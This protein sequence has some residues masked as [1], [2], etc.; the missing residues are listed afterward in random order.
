ML[1]RAL[2]SHYHRHP[3]QALFLLTGIVV[4]N[5]LLV[6]TL[7]INAQARASYEQGES[8]LRSG[9][10]GQVRHIDSDRTF[11]ERH[12]LRLRLQGFDMLAPVLRRM[13]FGADGEALELV[14]ID[15]FAM[16]RPRNG[17]DR[18]EEQQGRVSGPGF[19]G[20]AFPPYQLWAAPARLEQLGWQPG[21][22]P[23]LSTGETLPPATPVANEELGHRLLIDI[24][25]LQ[26]LTDSAGE[27]S[28]MLVFAAPPERIAALRAAL[29]SELVYVAGTQV[30]DPAELTRSFHLN[31]AAMGL[32][33][34]VVGVF[35]IYNALA[36]S[37]TDRR[38]LIRKLQ[39]SGVTRRE[40]AAALL[41]ELSVFLAAGSL[42][43]FW[44]GAQMAAWLLPGV[45]QTLAQLYGVYIAYPD[46]LVPSGF[47]L[48]LLMT[49]I[50]AVLCVLFPLRQALNTPLLQRWQAAWERRLAARRDRLM[51]AAGLALLTAAAALGISAESLWP[52]L[53]GMA[54]L[55]VGAV[56][57][58]P[59]VLR[60][61]LQ[62]LE[63]LIPPHRVRLAWLIA[64][65][66][67][68]IGPAALALMALTLALVANSGL[69]TMIGSFRQATDDWLD[70][71][72]AAQLYLRG[73]LQL[74]GLDE[75]LQQQD[76]RLRA[77]E[78]YRT[79]LNREAPA[80]R[81]A[82]VEV[83]SLQPGG[84]FL[85]GV[86]LIREAAG[87]GPRFT[88][89][90]GV[91]VSERA[92]RLDGWALGDTVPLCGEKPDLPVLGV[93]HDYGNPVSQWMVSQ[94]LFQHCWPGQR[95]IGRAIH[96]PDELDWYAIEVGLRT[97]FSLAA[98][99]LIDQAE[100]KQAGLAVFDRTFIVIQALNALTLLVA[101]IGIFCA[102]SAIHHHRV[103]QQALLA[104]LGMTR[105][106]RGSLLLL[107]WGLLGLLCMVMVWPFGT[108][109]AGYL[110]GIVT[111]LA[112][113]WSFPLR[114]Q[115]SHYL[116]LAGLAAACLVLAVA[117]PSLRLLRTSPAAMM[118][119][120]AL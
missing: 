69:N 67:W 66:R 79:R 112:F 49:A 61:L 55:L 73:D 109:L 33:A 96:G 90:E 91:Y 65:S 97:H 32:L 75:W 19:A 3:V 22:R 116:V 31:L 44:L 7:L 29:P 58:L 118:R 30:P 105:R 83:V 25:A 41:L 5:V 11:D 4:A 68:L 117:L 6:G 89:G 9:P 85:E 71:R 100:L 64:D 57:C 120:Q 36:F 62:I 110:A 111:P 39:L 18:E 14:G 34:F 99:Q 92:W 103:G 42:L 46:G 37:Y 28:S 84:R 60:G 8:L 114:L 115:W 76:P 80:R 106:E 50:A 81:A 43:G 78:R 74:P 98:D 47:L 86:G 10:L 113:G 72:L 20:F 48:P 13:V 87:A 52:A 35:L 101:G 40:L 17:D 95:P 24:G 88:A 53:A 59:T 82:A 119:E 93:Y 16:P 63:H 70:Q 1:R 12:Y 27:L 21:Q 108:V 51:L 54:A 23:P 38:E 26:A 56:L 94:T 45:G 107:Q 77:V 2:I 15:L 102:V 104:S